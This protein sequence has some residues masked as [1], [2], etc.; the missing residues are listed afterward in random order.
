M[1]TSSLSRIITQAAVRNNSTQTVY[2]ESKALI[3]MCGALAIV[4]W[5]IIPFCRG[6]CEAYAE[7]PDENNIV[8]LVLVSLSGYHSATL[9]VRTG[10]QR[11]SL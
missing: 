5:W 4:R 6:E 1:T 10:R 3:C 7:A 9:D 2:T 8:I 11:S